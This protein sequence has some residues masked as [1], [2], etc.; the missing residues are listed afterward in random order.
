MDV[1]FRRR[2]PATIFFQDTVLH[3]IVYSDYF[4]PQNIINCF[5]RV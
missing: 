4:M 1:T 5:F 2:T 3:L